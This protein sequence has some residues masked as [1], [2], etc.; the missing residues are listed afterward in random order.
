MKNKII[1]LVLSILFNH[2]SFSQNF[3]EVEKNNILKSRGYSIWQT[4]KNGMIQISKNVPKVVTKSDITV[5]NGLKTKDIGKTFYFN[6]QGFINA[7]TLEELIPAVYDHVDDDFVN[8]LILVQKGKKYLLLNNKGDSLAS[9]KISN[10]IHI[11]ISGCGSFKNCYIE[12]EGLRKV[13]SKDGKWGFVDNNWNIVIPCIYEKANG[14]ENGHSAVVQ[15]GIQGIIDKAGNFK[16]VANGISIGEFGNEGIAEFTFKNKKG[17]IDI[18]GKILIP[19]KYDVILFTEFQRKIS[20]KIGNKWV[21]LDKNGNIIIP[22]KKEIIKREVVENKSSDAKSSGVNVNQNSCNFKFVMPKITWKLVDNRRKCSYCRAQ[23]VPF[24]KVN[25]AEAK[26]IH[27][28]QY[29]Q[30]KLLKHWESVNASEEHK[31]IDRDKLKS[32]FRKNNYSEI[33]ILNAQMQEMLAPSIKTAI[34]A[35]K[36][37]L[38]NSLDNYYD[39]DTIYLYDVQETKYCSRK[40]QNEDY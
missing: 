11:D 25:L 39:F 38:D 5:E 7:S 27:S 33:A 15:S 35:R 20:T 36:A 12:R 26:Q 31:Q 18:N 4:E 17:V 8:D 2:L 21:D 6:K 1:L 13:K 22:E 23:F 16:P 24:T 34:N 32:L 29:L 19:A 40:C 30:G 14:F 10:F 3:S 9:K 28:V 37:F